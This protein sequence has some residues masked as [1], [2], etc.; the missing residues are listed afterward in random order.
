VGNLSAGEV[1]EVLE[2]VITPEG[3]RR[4]RMVQGWVSITAK[5]GTHSEPASTHSASR[6]Q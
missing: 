3:Q 2:D 5:S 6:Q 4:V 1:F